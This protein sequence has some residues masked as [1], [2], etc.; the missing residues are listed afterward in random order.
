M[1]RDF[2]K[3]THAIRETGMT[4]TEFVEEKLGD[5]YVN[6]YYRLRHNCL[7]L[8]DYH[9]ICFY[10]GRTFEDLFPNPFV[11]KIEPIPFR[12]P[13]T[14][15]NAPNPKKPIPQAIIQTPPSQDKEVVAPESVSRPAPDFSDQ[16]DLFNLLS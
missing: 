11:K 16:D 2:H 5:S 7:R 4:L 15:I 1:K 6:F 13:S 12:L 10:T 8:E 9:K 3:I 14:S